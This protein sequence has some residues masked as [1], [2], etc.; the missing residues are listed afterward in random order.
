[1]HGEWRQNNRTQEREGEE[2]RKSISQLTVEITRSGSLNRKI[3]IGSI[4][5]FSLLMIAVF[6]NW[7]I[8]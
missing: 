6:F 8:S 5:L 1:L 4:F 2:K 3:C 7:S